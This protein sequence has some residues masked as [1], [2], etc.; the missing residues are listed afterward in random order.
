[1]WYLAV[2]DVVVGLSEE[3]LAC[4][5]WRRGRCYQLCR[6]MLASTRR[7]WHVGAVANVNGGVVSVIVGMRPSWNYGSAW[8]AW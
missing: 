3:R 8:A 1:M 2:L 7:H 5:S 4:S 6:D